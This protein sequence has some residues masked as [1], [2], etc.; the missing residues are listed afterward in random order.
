MARIHEL[1]RQVA[2]AQPELAEQIKREYDQLGDRR[3][4]GLNF[5]RHTPEAVELPGRKVRRGDKVHVLPPRGETVKAE[6]KLLWIVQEIDKT[7][8]TPTSTLIR[9]VNPD[10]TETLQVPVED[11]VVVAEFRDPIYPGLLSTGRVERGGDKPFHSVINGENFHA[12][13]ALLFTH[14]GKVDAIYIDPPY[15]TGARDWKYNNDYV[16]AEDHYRH[17]KWLAFM[18]RRLLLARELLKSLDSV[19]VVTIDE[20]EFATLSLLLEQVF[21][22]R[23]L[24][25]VSIVHNPRGVQGNNFSYTNEFAIF[26]V[27]RGVRI[28]ASRKLTSEEQE[29]GASNLRNWGGE[30]LRSDAKN[31]FYPIFVKGDEI[32]GFGE[33]PKDEEHP[34][35]NETQSDGTVWVWPIDDSGVER[36]WRYARQ[37]VEKI[38]GQLAVKKSRNGSLGIQLIKDEGKY[39]TVWQ[40]TRHDA[41]T[42]GTQL[43][44]TLTGRQFPFPKSVYSVYEALH[45]MTGN[46]PDAT[47]LDFFSGSGTTMNATFLL[48]RVDGG[49][50][51]CI[52]VTNNEVSYEDQR[53]L[54]KLGLRPGDAEWEAKGICEYITKPRVRAA[55]TGNIPSG[56]PIKGD[57]KFADDF[58][59]SEGFEEN[60]EF[61]TLTYESAML[62]RSNRT[63]ERIAPLLWIAAGSRGRQILSVDSGWDLAESYGVITDLNKSE[64]FLK[65]IASQN[66]VTHVFIFTDE[67]RLFESIVR[68][69]PAGTEPVRMYEAYMR[70]FEEDAMRSA[71]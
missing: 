36:K 49:N 8:D 64:D 10:E 23:D 44:A 63:F 59:M 17:S 20:N 33:V 32:V 45:A 67:D 65:A 43:V 27:P 31:C 52:S 35:A 57:Y 55:V 68:E 58:P 37:S 50:R 48:N 56:E 21:P 18:E 12:L 29:K 60:V 66:S 53:A 62:V 61:F 6:N 28:I 22:D 4:F 54:I 30:S 15:N 13:Q 1:I 2:S 19:L 14:R 46:K 26:A 69:L 34:K 3:A 39:K 71:R 40:D 16:E 9:N 51:T 5:E 38:Q 11:L 7:S 24:I 47:I 70:N 25:S 42:Y 41:S